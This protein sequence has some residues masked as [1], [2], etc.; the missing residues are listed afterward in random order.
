M[1]A[2]IKALID[3]AQR[4][5]NCWTC[6][7]SGPRSDNCYGLTFDDDEDQPIIDWL[8]AAPLAIDGTVPMHSDG[9][10][11]WMA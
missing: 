1:T 11:G 3:E 5:T 2:P 8:T 7:L 10:P 4:L 9:C 6:S